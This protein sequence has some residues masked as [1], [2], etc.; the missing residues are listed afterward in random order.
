MEGK[1]KDC[2]FGMGFLRNDIVFLVFLL[3]VELMVFFIKEF[4]D[5]LFC[6]WR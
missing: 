3:N 2:F 5:W 1:K 6:F 4:M